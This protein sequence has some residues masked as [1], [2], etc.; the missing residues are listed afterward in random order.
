MAF[1]HDVEL[2]SE[3]QASIVAGEAVVYIIYA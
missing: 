1:H 2:L 3:V